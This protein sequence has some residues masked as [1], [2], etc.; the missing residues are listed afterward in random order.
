[1]NIMFIMYS[2]NTTTIDAVVVLF[3]A[4][5]LKLHRSLLYTFPET[6]VAI[7]LLMQIINTSPCLHHECWQ[8]ESPGMQPASEWRL[9]LHHVAYVMHIW[10]SGMVLTTAS[11]Q[12]DTYDRLQICRL[13]IP[14]HA[15]SSSQNAKLLHPE[16]TCP[17]PRSSPQARAVL[18]HFM[19]Y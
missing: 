2:N 19:M 16:A 13:Q 14:L 3:V 18:L 9:V 15:P 5:Q 17:F 4:I 8:L 12:G 6:A 1:M 10:E 11:T 7:Q